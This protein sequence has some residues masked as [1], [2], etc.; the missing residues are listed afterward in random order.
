MNRI[1][2]LSLSLIKTYSTSLP[3]EYEKTISDIDRESN[4]YLNPR[5]IK[6]LLKPNFYSSNQWNEYKRLSSILL[7]ISKKVIYAYYNNKYIQDFYNFDP[8]LH[9]LI[10]STPFNYMLPCARIDLLFHEAKP[11]LCEINCDGSAGMRKDMVVNKAILSL[12]PYEE[13]ARIYNISYKNLISAQVESYINNVI[14]TK[15]NIAQLTGESPIVAIVNFRDTNDFQEN[16]LY[17]CEYAKHGINALV[18]DP[19]DLVYYNRS[20]YY[21]G[22][23]INF[24]QKEVAE[25]KLLRY[26]EDCYDFIKAMVDSNVCFIGSALGK[27]IDD[28]FFFALLH[29]NLL[30]NILNKRE[31]EFIQCYI[32]LTYCFK[33]NLELFNLAKADKNRYLIKSRDTYGGAGVIAGITLSDSDWIN[34]IEESW[35]SNWIIQEFVKTDM[36][37]LPCVYDK[38]LSY[39]YFQTTVGLFCYNMTLAG[40]YSRASGEALINDYGTKDF[41]VANLYYEKR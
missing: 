35:N 33:D 4:K 1:D 6:Y 10:M 2:E 34:A 23:K 16:M 31:K 41:Y 12:S 8:L 26:Q 13:L 14:R 19:R 22:Q 20:L 40:L 9:Q 30:D 25:A 3:E 5:R 7:T 38:N 28:K 24:V 36:D 18:A 21:N 39:E 27:I 29:S 17:V 11:M 37:Y 32:P 15:L